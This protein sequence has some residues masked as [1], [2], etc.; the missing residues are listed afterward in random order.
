MMMCGF[1]GATI[2]NAGLDGVLGFAPTEIGP[3]W[4]LAR[5]ALISRF[6]TLIAKWAIAAVLT[7]VLTAIVLLV[8][9]G[10]LG[11][12]APEPLLLWAYGWFCAAVVAVGTLAL[13]AVLGTPGQLVGL[14]LFVYL[15]LASAGGTVPV[16]ALPDAFAAVSHLDPLRQILAGVRSI[17]YLEA[18]ADAGLAE[19]AIATAIG[20]IFWL[21]FGAFF[22]RR[23]DRAGRDRLD[24]ELLAY[25]HRSAD[26]YRPSRQA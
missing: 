19:G 10:A 26:E 21:C 13:F 2:V 18:R 3:K 23:Y 7:G 15:G 6:Q 25:V 17:L 8:A 9:A 20:L 14:L 24:P 11:M 5:P 4:T 12:D 1:I 16:Q 22:V